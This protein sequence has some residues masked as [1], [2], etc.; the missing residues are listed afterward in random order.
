MNRFLTVMRRLA[1]LP[2]VQRLMRVPF[3]QR[4]GMAL[5]FYLFQE[6]A[7]FIRSELLARQSTGRYH[8]RP[9]GIAV[10]LRHHSPDIYTLDEI[11][12][13]QVYDFPPTVLKA[14]SVARE[15]PLE[16]LDLGAN[17]GLFGAYVLARFGDARITALEP[18][19]SNASI[20]RCCI[21]A[22]EREETWKL[23]ESY[24]ST[25]DGQAIFVAGNFAT[26]HGAAGGEKGAL[27]V[28]ARDVFHHMEKVDLLKIDIEGSEWPILADERFPTVAAR[29][30]ALE[31]HPRMCPSDDPEAEARRLLERAGFSVQQV[32]RRAG[33]EG[34]LWAWRS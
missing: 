15:R 13:Q 9:A 25:A 22:N 34:M 3:A 16:V 4:V 17:I 1:L 21:E 10:C 6:R 30:V 33:G 11:F 18:D 12:A 8:L 2:G 5:R 27:P 31:Y 23:W 24:A 29:A 32:F 7:R 19:P 20:H 14:L 28:E 26:S